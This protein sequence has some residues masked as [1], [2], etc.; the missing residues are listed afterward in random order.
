MNDRAAVT[1]E[2]EGRTPAVAMTFGGLPP[3]IASVR[4]EA[5]S[6]FE[7]YTFTAN[8]EPVRVGELAESAHAMCEQI[9]RSSELTRGGAPS[10]WVS[11]AGVDAGLVTVLA[12]GGGYCMGSADAS[13]MHADLHGLLPFLAFVDTDE[14]LHDDAVRLVGKV[15]SAGG[16]ATLEIGGGMIHVWPLL[17]VLPEAETAV[18]LAGRFIA[19][20]STRTSA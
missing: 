12:H 8:G 13:P 4:A 3:F 9:V 18:A 1:V 20:P 6:G 5:A 7:H 16:H 14:G 11:A 10:L 2:V 19:E 15:N 17:P